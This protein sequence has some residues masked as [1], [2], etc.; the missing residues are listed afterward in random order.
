MTYL[1]ICT[2]LLAVAFAVRVSGE[3][4]ARRAGR[5][6]PLAPTVITATVLVVL[7]I[8]F[9]NLMIAA[10]LFAYADAEIWGL[11]IGWAPVEDLA[12]PLALAV[13]LPG[14]WELASGR[15]RR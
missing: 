1:L 2:G 10:G 13:M 14:V 11:R 5:R 15:G 8:V 3:V 6:I 12:Y 7:T 9:D 4:R